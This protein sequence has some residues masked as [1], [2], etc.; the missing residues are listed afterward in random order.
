MERMAK[1]LSVYQ[2]NLTLTL[3]ERSK[4]SILVVEPNPEARENVKQILRHLNFPTIFEASNHL[5]AIEKFLERSITH[6]IFD[7]QKSSM[8]PAE[9]VTKILELNPRTI[10]ISSSA[11]P[12]LDDVF[13]LL[14]KGARGYLIKPYTLEGVDEAI[15]LATK[16]EPFP[17]AVLQ[18]KDRNEALAVLVVTALDRLATVIKHAQEFETA[19]Q[20]L[21]KHF[22]LLQRAVDLA[23]TFSR[24][25]EA[26]YL[27][28]FVRVCKEKQKLPSSRLGRLR[29]KLKIAKVST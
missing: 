15:I 25:E 9:F 24:D 4:I 10:L 13:S 22:F 6:V 7:S 23:V 20:E 16:S 28:S 11:N 29:K 21:P 12:K 2:T 1:K 5:I 14:T 27:E 18:A 3:A 8:P 19:K 26:G 17:E